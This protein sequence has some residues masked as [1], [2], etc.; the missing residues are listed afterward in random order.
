MS[1][2]LQPLLCL[3]N[4]NAL[5]RTLEVAAQAKTALMVDVPSGAAYLRHGLGA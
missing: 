2:L 1:I 4:A 3:K 5:P